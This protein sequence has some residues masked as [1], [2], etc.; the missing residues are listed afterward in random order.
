MSHSNAVE[1]LPYLWIGNP[2]SLL[3]QEYL[4][5]ID[6]IISDIEVDQ[7][8]PEKEFIVYDPSI[9]LSQWVDQISIHYQNCRSILLVTSNAVQLISGFLFKFGIKK[10][11]I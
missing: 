1:I 2:Q 7:P 8:V 11:D 6:I 4:K 10:E 3:D 5:Q 9:K